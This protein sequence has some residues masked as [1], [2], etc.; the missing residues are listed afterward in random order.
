[1]KTFRYSKDGTYIYN[2]EEVIP[3]NHRLYEDIL[4]SNCEILP[5]EEPVKTWLE[6]RMAEYPSLD[7]CIEALLDGGQS[8]TDLQAKRQAIKLKYP[9]Q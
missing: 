3:T 8:L 1:M 5:Y 2:E 6:K 7:K 9:K 4:K